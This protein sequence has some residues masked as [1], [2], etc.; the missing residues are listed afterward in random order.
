MPQNSGMLWSYSAQWASQGAE[1]SHCELTA[2]PVPDSQHKQSNKNLFIK[3]TL[4]IIINH[5]DTTFQEQRNT[6]VCKFTLQTFQI[7]L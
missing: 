6:Y 5:L 7:L 2:K 3:Q 4:K 1:K